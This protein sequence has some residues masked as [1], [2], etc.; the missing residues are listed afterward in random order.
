MR[1]LLLATAMMLG[2][3]VPASALTFTL[4]QDH[5]TGTCGAASYGTATINQIGTGVEFIINLT[6]SVFQ[7]TGGN[8]GLTTVNFGFTGQTFTQSD[9]VINSFNG[10]ATTWTLVQPNPNQDGF[11]DFL[12]GNNG[13]ANA[14]GVNSGGTI[15]DFTILGAQLA[16]LA[17]S[18]DGGASTQIAVDILGLNGNTGLVGGT[19]STFPPPPPP[20]AETPLPGAVWL[21]G[22]GLA[23]L[24]ALNKRRKKKQMLELAAA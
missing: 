6:N 14:N 18:T 5:C 3:S 17:F 4:D 7:L 23:G 2:L 10:P 20:P 15:L 9:L 22:T 19:P 16:N 13:D 1:K 12:Q 24:Y 8:G 21:F 11:G